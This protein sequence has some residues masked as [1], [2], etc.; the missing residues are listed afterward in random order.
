[1]GHL[2]PSISRSMVG[3]RLS[4]L[5]HQNSHGCPRMGAVWAL[6]AESRSPA[7]PGRIRLDPSGPLNTQWTGSQEVRGFESHRLHKGAG[8][9]HFILRDQGCRETC[10]AAHS[11]TERRMARF[12]IE[13]LVH[14]APPQTRCP[15]CLAT[16][17][18]TGAFSHSAA[19]HARLYS[20]RTSLGCRRFD[21]SQITWPGGRRQSTGRM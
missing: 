5:C 11:A 20:P 16:G 1:M 9:R 17:T 12:D 13:T 7:Q 6:S 3:A 14:F 21:Q 2:V 4:P 15:N 19:E 18:R 10:S 8:Q